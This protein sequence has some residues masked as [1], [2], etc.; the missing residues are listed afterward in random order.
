MILKGSQ[1]GGFQQRA[2]H[3]FKMERNEHI[4]AHEVRGF[5]SDNLCGALKEIY[6]VN[7]KQDVSNSCFIS[8]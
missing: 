3:L 6:S 2:Y 4:E 7:Q 8:A 5:M 1:L